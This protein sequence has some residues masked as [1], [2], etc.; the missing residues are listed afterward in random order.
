MVVQI[1]VHVI[2]REDKIDDMK[3]LLGQLA[4]RTKRELTCMHCVVAQDT[5]DK[6][7]F[8]VMQT[9]E[10]PDMYNKHFQSAVNQDFLNKIKEISSVEPAIHQVA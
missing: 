5:S 6:K 10:R 3:T 4:E 9:W 2:A 7:D 1:I 8:T